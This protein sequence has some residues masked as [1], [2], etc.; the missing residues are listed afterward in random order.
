MAGDAAPQATDQLPCVE[1]AMD[2][3]VVVDSDDDEMFSHEL[4]QVRSILE[5][6]IL[7]TLSMP[8]KNRSRLPRKPLSFAQAKSGC[9][10]GS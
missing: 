1:A 6:A 8:L 2:L 10:E 9:S 3:P 5:E 7:E 4:E